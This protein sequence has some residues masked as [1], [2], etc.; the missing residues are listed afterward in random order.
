LL[1]RARGLSP[2]RH[3]SQNHRDTQALSPSQGKGP[4]T[5]GESFWSIV[6][7]SLSSSHS[8]FIHESSLVITS[9]DI[10]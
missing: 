7:P 4:T 8:W 10:W 6:R 5:L 2:H 1:R 3:H 9:R